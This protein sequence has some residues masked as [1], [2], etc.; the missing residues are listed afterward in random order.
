MDAYELKCQYNIAETCC[1]SISVDQLRELSES[2][3]KDIFQTSTPL[4]YGA[5]RGS[6]ALRNNLARLYSA[7]SANPLPPDQILTTPGAIQANYLCAYALVGPGD[8]V[9]CH[10]PTCECL[11]ETFRAER[12][13][14]H[15]RPISLRSAQTTGTYPPKAVSHHRH[16]S[17]S[18]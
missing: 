15:R 17:K 13:S 11:R 18:L 1:A 12:D 4:T 14:S 8:H 10:Y 6:D 3:N 9:I 5:I 2:K 16:V 7:K